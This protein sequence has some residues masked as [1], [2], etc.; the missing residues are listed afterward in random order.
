MPRVLGVRWNNRNGLFF[1]L[2]PR[3]AP[4]L[5]WAYFREPLLQQDTEFLFYKGEVTGV[6]SLM[7]W[8]YS[9]LLFWLPLKFPPSLSALHSHWSSCMSRFPEC[10]PLAQ[11]GATAVRGSPCLGRRQYCSYKDFL[12][13][14]TRPTPKVVFTSSFLSCFCPFYWAIL[15][16]VSAVEN[17]NTWIRKR[18]MSCP[19]TL[20][21]EE[22]LSNSGNTS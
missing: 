12:K 1:N 8:P 4:E 13:M 7:C 19:Q 18:W 10:S 15:A 9:A 3:K 22:S 20:G 5:Y 17:R 11:W 6:E 2:S 16:F 21:W 14:I